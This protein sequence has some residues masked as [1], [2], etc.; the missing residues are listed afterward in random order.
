MTLALALLACGPAGE[1]GRGARQATT[2][3][4]TGSTP[5]PPALPELRIEVPTTLE[6]H[7]P[8]GATAGVVLHNDGDEDLVVVEVQWQGDP[9]LT[10][11]PVSL[12]LT[13]APGGS[14]LVRVRS[15][16]AVVGSASGTLTVASNDPRGSIEAGFSAEVSYLD[17]VTQTFVGPGRPMVDVVMLVD[18]TTAAAALV[19]LQ[20]GLPGLVDELDANTSW[21]VAV[22]TEDSGCAEGVVDLTSPAPVSALVGA[23]GSASV[24]LF[25]E[26]LLFIGD[27]ALSRTGAGQCNEDLLR[28]GAP[29]HLI[30]VSDEREQSGHTGAHWV[31]RFEQSVG[32]GSVTVSGIVDRDHG[33]GDGSGPGGYSDAIALTDG[34]TLDICGPFGPWVPALADGVTDGAPA[35]DLLASPDPGSVVVTVDGATVPHT[36]LGHSVVLGAPVAANAAV[37]ITY[38][39]LDTCP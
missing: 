30:L 8:C 36:L 19:E 25:S 28:P 39:A 38:G 22:V 31:D 12:P 1:A 14:E 29:L 13:L 2:S 5:A 26:Q 10:V 11:D 6:H 35:Y 24:G 21:R 34:A 27:R 15:D 18:A 3:T 16:G 4:D 32:T 23:V 7:V 33:C 9:G 20:G 17:E 37:S